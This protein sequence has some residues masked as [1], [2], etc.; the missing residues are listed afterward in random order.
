MRTESDI[1][2]QN[3]IT[4]AGI[5]YMPKQTSKRVLFTVVGTLRRV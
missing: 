1:I 2:W 4:K 5:I 3:I